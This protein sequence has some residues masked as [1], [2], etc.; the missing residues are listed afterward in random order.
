MKKFFL[1]CVIISS[2]FL[3]ALSSNDIPTDIEKVDLKLKEDQMALTFL[4]LPSGEATLIQH[5]NGKTILINTGGPATTGQLNELLNMYNITH[6][7]TVILTK[8]NNEY[9]SNMDWLASNYVIGNFIVGEHST[10][11]FVKDKKN[12]IKWK[13]GDKH[14]LLPDLTIHV[15]Q[16]SEDIEGSL[17][18]DLLLTYGNHKVLYMTS[19]NIEIEKQLLNEMDLSDVDIIKVPEFASKKGTSE[20]FIEHVDPQ[21]A[22]IF[23]KRGVPLSQGVIERLQET[24]IDIYLTKQLGNISIKCNKN[25]YEIITISV[26]SSTQ[27]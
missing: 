26:E 16:E 11:P 6:I 5:G 22:I 9:N 24:W 14:T 10:E 19:S 20:S 4:D 3:T 21:V 15:I 13:K 23:Q 8:K 27:V 7:D 12:V 1:L 17:G 25:D 18:M 2:V